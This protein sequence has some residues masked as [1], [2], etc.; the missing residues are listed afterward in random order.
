MQESESGGPRTASGALNYDALAAAYS[1]ARG[2]HEGVLRGLL[3][4]G[5]VDAGT[6]VLEVGCGTGNYASAVA[7]V[8][9][10][11]WGIDPSS[12]MLAVARGRTETLRLVKGTAEHL[13][14]RSGSLDLVF[15]VDVI[16]H[17][18]DR[19]AY[20]RE[21][22]RILR[23]GGRICTVT[24]SEWIIRNRQPLSNYFPETVDVEL[25][26]YPSISD[27]LHRMLEAGLRSLPEQMVE[28][29]DELTDI[30]PY[31]SKAFSS[32]HLI[33]AVAH[34]MGIERMR[35]DLCNG[36]IARVSRY[37]MLWANKE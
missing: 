8:A 6:R 28:S 37:V 25:V 30:S 3:A 1:V 33:P 10:Q 32:L 22:N 26:R 7:S 4:G 29:R 14:F 24:D 5:S 36:P 2:T 19:G 15:S 20:F 11:C 27:L 35:E 18:R 12:A 31:E 23:A 9:G 21:A 17:V 34:R 13:P 16:H